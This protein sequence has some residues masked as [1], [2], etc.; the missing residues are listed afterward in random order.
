[1]TCTNTAL[2][3][4]GAVA[5]WYSAR[6]TTLQ[7]TG[8]CLRGPHYATPKNNRAENERPSIVR[9]L[10]STGKGDH[11]IARADY[12]AVMGTGASSSPP[13]WAV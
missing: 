3:C 7:L 4:R 8:R 5:R 11:A 2:A 6:S 1:M 13:A 12:E 10:G 9:C